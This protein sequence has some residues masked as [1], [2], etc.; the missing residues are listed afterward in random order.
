MI[1]MQHKCVYDKKC[2]VYSKVVCVDLYHRIGS[3]I[4]I[5]YGIKRHWANSVIYPI[6]DH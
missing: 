4:Y 6:D 5:V 2:S 3:Y 1:Y